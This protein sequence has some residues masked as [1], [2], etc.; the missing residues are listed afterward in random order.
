MSGETH[1]PENGKE[2]FVSEVDTRRRRREEYERE[3]DSSFWQSVGMMGTIGW[4][5]SIPTALGVLLGR[6]IDGRLESAH[7]FMVF[8]MLVG[9]ITGCV[10]AWRMVAEKM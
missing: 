9:L 7:V 2:A 10:T 1:K 8:F 3:G 5:V 6:W 4:S